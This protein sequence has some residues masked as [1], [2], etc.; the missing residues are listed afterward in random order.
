[1]IEKQKCYLY[2]FSILSVL[3]MVNEVFSGEI[4]AY[5]GLVEFDTTVEFVIIVAV[6]L[7]NILV[8][9]GDGDISI[10]KLIIC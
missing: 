5:E 7:T 2:K 4:V 9:I 8:L 3:T 10:V 6:E 1:M